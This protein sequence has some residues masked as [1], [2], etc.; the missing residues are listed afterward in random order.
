[1]RNTAP[2]DSSHKNTTV[3]SFTKLPSSIM[4]NETAILSEKAKHIWKTTLKPDFPSRLAQCD[5]LLT[6]D[7]V[8]KILAYLA[9]Y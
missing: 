1:M 2:L 5:E 8:P 9:S 7:E 4:L 6:N 3:R